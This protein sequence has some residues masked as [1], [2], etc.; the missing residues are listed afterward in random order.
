[1]RAETGDYNELQRLEGL[2]KVT[3][4]GLVRRSWVEES[5]EKIWKPSLRMCS[6]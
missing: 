6:R 2:E 5:K 1:M 4:G 3:E